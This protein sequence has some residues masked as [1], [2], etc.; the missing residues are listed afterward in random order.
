MSYTP[1]FIEALGSDREKAFV[2]SI[3]ASTDRKRRQSHGTK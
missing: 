3:T 2:D 1:I